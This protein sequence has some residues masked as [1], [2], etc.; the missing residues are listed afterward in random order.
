LA[1]RSRVIFETTI[2]N[3]IP[4]DKADERIRRMFGQIAPWYDTLNHVLSLNIDKRW[5]RAVVKRV[6]PRGPAP[7]LDVCTGTGDLA[8][9][10]YAATPGTRTVI[11]T[12]FTHEM[13]VRANEK[14]AKANAQQNVTF[15]EAD[16]QALPFAGDTFAIVSVAF[17]L[18]NVH[19]T[20]LGLAEMVRVCR[21]GGTVVVLEFSRPRH[22]LVG[23]LYRWYFQYLLPCIGQLF[24]RNRESAYRYLPQ[25]VMQFPDGEAL[26]DRLRDAGLVNVR[27][28][29]LTFGIATLYAG[30][31][32]E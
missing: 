31:K 28:E 14:A 30:D 15:H 24:A 29:P 17:G 26:C 27:H 6:P 9:D 18:R 3:T 7:I 16:T 21:P 1:V 10:Y 19:D 22:W 12:D 32:P 5:R 13:L 20:D 8:L 4:V 2:L 11:G 23:R 25:S